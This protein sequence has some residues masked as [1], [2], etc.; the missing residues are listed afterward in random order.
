M[1]PEGD[2]GHLDTTPAMMKER[3]AERNGVRASGIE[4]TT[5]PPVLTEPMMKIR[6]VSIRR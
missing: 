1:S 2:V 4:Q 5:P 6:I 3:Q